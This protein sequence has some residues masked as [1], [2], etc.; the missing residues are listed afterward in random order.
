MGQINKQ[1]VLLGGLLAGLINN[2]GGIALMYFLLAED[3]AAVMEN[4]G[5]PRPAPYWF[6]IHLATNFTTGIAAVWLYAAV[7]PRFGPG[8]KT[9]L[10]AAVTIWYFTLFLTA[11]NDGSMGFAPL[12]FYFVLAV[13]GFFQILL[14]TT[15]GA[16][17]YKEN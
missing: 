9:A 14:A 1:R 2:V 6:F 4:L 16:W 13:G 10:V 8:P 7:R 3:L 15:A 17:I 5:L 12:R 11:I